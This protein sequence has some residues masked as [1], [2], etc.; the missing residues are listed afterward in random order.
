MATREELVELIERWFAAL[1]SGDPAGLPL[2]PGVR[3]TDNGTPIAPGEGVWGATTA[4]LGP[5]QHPVAD[6]ELGQVVSWALVEEGGETILG[7][8]LGVRDGLIAEVEL[9]ACR[10]RRGKEGGLLWVPGLMRTR[11]VLAEPVAPERRAGREEV[12]A[13]AHGYL[14]AIVESDASLVRVRD[15]CLRIENGVQCVRNDGGEDLPAGRGDEPYWRMGVAEQVRTGIF[16]DIE[17]AAERRVLAVDVERGLVALT[18][19]F[20]HPGPTEANGFTSRYTE[21]NGMVIME[22]WKVDDGEIV[23]IESILDV[24]EYGRPLGWEA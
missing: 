12:V 18:F 13:A 5:L 2:A 1:P 20:D 4:V 9:L 19:R 24:F 8:R 3:V 17:A 22:I 10:P 23:H 6:P 7:A 14:D 21:P 16:T 15:E 11:P